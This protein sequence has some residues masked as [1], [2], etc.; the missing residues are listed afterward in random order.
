MEKSSAGTGIKFK[1]LLILLA[2]TVSS[3]FSFAQD[4]RS[5]MKNACVIPTSEFCFTE[6]SCEFNL[7]I[8][9]I[10]PKYVQFYID[11]VP[12]SVNFLS[13]QKTSDSKGTLITIFFQFKKTGTFKLDPIVVD[14]KGYRFYVP[15]KSVIVYENLDTLKPELLVDFSNKLYNR[16]DINI[17][18]AAG[19]HIR[20]ALNMKYVVQILDFSYELPKNSV[21]TEVK[22]YPLADGIP[23]GNSFS[24]EINP[25]AVFDW[26]PLEKGTWKLPS[27]KITATSYNGVRYVIGFPDITVNVTEK[28][29]S[30]D[31]TLLEKKSVFAYAFSEIEP[32]VTDNEEKTISDEEL[33]FLAQL[34]KKEINSLPFS[35]TSKTRA[36]LEKEAGMEENIREPS[37][38]LLIVLCSLFI[39]LFVFALIKMYRKKYSAAA[40]F[41]GGA[42]IILV[43]SINLFVRIN[44]KTAIFRGEYLSP[45]PEQNSSSNVSLKKGSYI[46]VTKKA[47]NWVYIKCNETYGWTLEENIIY[48]NK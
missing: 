41:S 6:K 45:V 9:S 20:F 42:L 39:I 1:R 7:Y 31:G 12:D 35:K 34:R 37:I 48:I 43:L 17:S 28:I 14:V 46:Q 24:P 16:D 23:L 5:V 44:K 2:L 36:L 13:S 27:V 21:F 18:I 8:E 15:F 22:R 11:K 3:V 33:N 40:I 47:G 38:P 25:V 10:E 29:D 30:T 32:S 4:V 19:D 26:Q